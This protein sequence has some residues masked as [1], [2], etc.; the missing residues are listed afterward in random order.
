MESLQPFRG[1]QNLLVG[2]QSQ[3]LIDRMGDD[4]GPFYGRLQPRDE[5]GARLLDRPQPGEVHIPPINHIDAVRL[6]GNLGCGFD[7]VDLSV[8]DG[9]KGRNF[10]QGNRDRVKSMFALSRN[11]PLSLIFLFMAGFGMMTQIASSNTI[12]QTIVDE[13][14]RGRVMSLYA[15]SLMGM[16]PFGSLMA[17]TVAGK[18]EVHNTLLL[19]A[20][21]CITGALI[22]AG[23]LP[24]IRAMVR[25]VYRRM[26]ITPETAAANHAG[27][28][29]DVQPE[30]E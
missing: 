13:D 29:E 12:L 22:F 4:T 19:G 18:I 8:G 30:E 27:A 24:Q 28:K 10:A 25:P 14:K 17:G 9:Q 15:M 3:R 5:K 21:F 26:G 6:D 11:F 23:K 7:I 1:K 16:M 20:A 2:A